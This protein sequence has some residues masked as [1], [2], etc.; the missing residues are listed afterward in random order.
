MRLITILFIPW[1][2]LT[3]SFS[4]LRAPGETGSKLIGV[5][6]QPALYRFLQAH[7][8]GVNAAL[9]ALLQAVSAPLTLYLAAGY[10]WWILLLSLLATS[11]LYFRHRYL[12]PSGASLALLFVLSLWLPAP[13]LGAWWTVP[14]AV[15]HLAR[16]GSA[17]LRQLIL[18]IS[19][20]VA[21]AGSWQFTSFLARDQLWTSRDAGFTGALFFLLCLAFY[22]AAWFIGDSRRLRII[23]QQQLIE[24]ATRLEY[25]SEQERKLAAG[26][27][28][29]R[30]AREMHDI[31]AHSL[32]VIIAQADGGRYAVAAQDERDAA[33]QLGS[34]TLGTISETARES[35]AQMRQLL[36]VLRTTEETEYAPAPDVSRLP[37]LVDSFRAAGLPAHLV[38]P[39]SPVHDSP[40][41]AEL[42]VY[43]IVQEALTNITKHARTSPR[44]EVSLKDS[45]TSLRV[46][47]LNAPP[48]VR[49]DPLPG[50]RRGL[51]GMRERVDLYGGALHY[52]PL[53]DG[54][55]LLRATLPKKAR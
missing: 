33:V 50:A 26:D 7:R 52:G 19:P 12:R 44:V 13:M 25:E 29:T 45:A 27:E 6:D 3:S 38:V 10:S 28:R 49:T 37:E 9:I 8:V 15:Y 51:A 5:T 30:I 54:G 21:L 17:M 43:R 14:L 4:Q 31:V 46:S 11:T 22:L 42:V 2:E 23:Y 32:S 41:G 39:S 36:G 53:E 1:Y 16:Y 40:Q 24:R 20:L 55:F 48:T 47:V 35:L 18:G 34:Q